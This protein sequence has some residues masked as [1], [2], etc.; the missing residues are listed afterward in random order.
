MN[1][2]GKPSIAVTDHPNIL[3]AVRVAT[4]YA[5]PLATV[6]IKHLIKHFNVSP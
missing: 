6:K 2:L 1:N 5:P 3:K 4:Q